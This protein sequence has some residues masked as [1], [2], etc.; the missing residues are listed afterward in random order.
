MAMGA[1]ASAR[2]LSDY[3]VLWSGKQVGEFPPAHLSSDYYKQYTPLRQNL[4]AE[5]LALPSAHKLK[6]IMVM[7][8]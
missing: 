5:K 3:S 1:A 6:P 2:E 8:G 4:M 7:H